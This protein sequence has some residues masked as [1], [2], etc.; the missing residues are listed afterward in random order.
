MLAKG[1]LV[2]FYKKEIGINWLV[3][4]KYRPRD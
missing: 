4:I 1:Y 3:L 2:M